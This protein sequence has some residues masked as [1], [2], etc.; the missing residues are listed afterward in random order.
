MEFIEVG[1][2]FA[3]ALAF[4]YQEAVSLDLTE[5]GFNLVISLSNPDQSEIKAIKAEECK[6]A[7]T[8]IS[9]MISL[10]YK[11]GGMPWSDAGFSIHL[12]ENKKLPE[13]ATSES[14]L[15]LYIYLVEASSTNLLV[16]RSVT[17]SPNFSAAFLKAVKEQ[18]QEKWSGEQAYRAACQQIYK[19]YSPNDLVKLSIA[20][21]RGGG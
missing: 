2:P 1:K 10:S 16:M 14:R 17:L 4:N 15:V 19:Q 7:L 11:F 12:I 18:E 13:L 21:S 3:Q 9:P 5:S 6:F 8:V 20:Q